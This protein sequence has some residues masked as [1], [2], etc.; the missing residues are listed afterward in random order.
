[1][2]AVLVVLV[3]LAALIAWLVIGSRGGTQAAPPA[4]SP[5][6]QT[7][8]PTTPGMGD[9]PSADASG[10]AS[11][12]ASPSSSADSD[13]KESEKKKD[14][15]SKGA[16]KKKDKDSKDA[17]KKKDAGP[18]ACA[19]ETVRTT[20]TGAKSVKAKEKQDYA[21]SLIN[22][23]KE[24]C[25]LTLDADHF[26]LRIYSGTDRIWSSADCAKTL[27]A[28]EKK[29]KPEQAHE[30]KMDWNGARSAEKCT[31]DN[32]TIRPGTY[33]ATAQFKGAEPT[34]HVF[35]IKG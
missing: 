33:V 10:T 32:G 16:D 2:A 17:D 30:W 24:D 18:K 9:T 29:L 3:L 6:P 13:Q 5:E 19:P 11:P 15:D 12:T 28:T 22:G 34:Q 20:L 35:T 1:R 23:S 31:V 14:K 4:D 25:V 26:E 7:S 8:A 21:L 27:K